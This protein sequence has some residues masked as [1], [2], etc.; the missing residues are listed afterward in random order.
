MD[1]ELWGEA[2]KGA[3]LALLF[4]TLCWGAQAAQVDPAEALE[5]AEAALAENALE[6]AEEAVEAGLRAVPT[7]SALERDL[8][9]Q[10]AALRLMRSDWLGA[11]ALLLDAERSLPEGQPL[12]LEGT[13]NLLRALLGLPD[14][15]EEDLRLKP[16]AAAT[17][18][19]GAAFR[20]LENGAMLRR[21]QV[22][23]RRLARN[24]QLSQRLDALEARMAG[25]E[26]AGQGA[27]NLSYAELLGRFA[28]NLSG[29]AAVELQ[30]REARALLRAEAAGRAQGDDR[31]RSF[32]LGMQG[33][34]A[35]RGGDQ[36]AAETLY[37][38]AL[39]LAQRS[40]A[41]E[42]RYRWRWRLGEQ[43]L[44]RGAE[45][46]AEHHL[47]LAVSLLGEVRGRLPSRSSDLFFRTM[48]PVY[49]RY[50]D[51]LLRQAK[52]AEGDE[53][54]AYLARVQRVLEA[55]RTAEVE[56]YFSRQCVTQN[57]TGALGPGSAALYPI[58]LEDRLTLLLR[59]DE[60]YRMETVTVSREQVRDVATAFR[61]A[62]EQG[63]DPAAGREDGQTLYNWLLAPLEQNGALKDIQ[64]LL[65][66]PDGVLRTIPL[67]ALHDGQRYL[68]ERYAFVTVPALA[69]A[70]RGERPNREAAPALLVGGLS[71]AVQ[72]FSPLPGV[73][74]EV[75]LLESRFSADVVF[76]QAFSE[77]AV[78]RRFAEGDYRIAH[79]ATHGT[80]SSDHRQSFLLTYEDVLSLR[81]L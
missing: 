51:V 31:L 73:A 7:G 62:I 40:G 41:L 22:S 10:G 24:A 50:V 79:F 2:M 75:S 55:Q 30:A 4:L 19:R 33:E 32:A 43:A 72:G 52:R 8:L 38:L 58:L 29:A 18:T 64:T 39:M 35:Q 78:R 16:A 77:A 21:A 46:A 69:L 14:S 71:D 20:S 74:R 13:L 23:L 48:V 42:A 3:I 63:E 67:A 15:W 12:P 37:G 70:Q 68:L 1:R 28:E 6:A 54:A 59:R 9:N 25:R 45:A 5:I 81:A 26:G 57:E 60:G 44:A 65:I 11:Y 61:L 47:G 53:R 80:F 56:D 17:A 27:L 49:E 66:I 76:N 36:A 34:A